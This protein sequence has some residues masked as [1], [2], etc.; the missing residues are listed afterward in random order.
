MFASHALSVDMSDVVNDDSQICALCYVEMQS[1]I[2][3]SCTDFVCL[4]ESQETCEAGSETRA[5][6]VACLGTSLYIDSQS[7]DWYRMCDVYICFDQY[8]WS[9]EESIWWYI[10]NLTS[11]VVYLYIC[12]LILTALEESPRCC[13]ERGSISIRGRRRSEKKIESRRSWRFRGVDLG[14]HIDASECLNTL[15]CRN[16]DYLQGL[17]GI[18]TRKSRLP[19]Y[20]FFGTG[21]CK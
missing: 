21:V 14:S 18:T 16:L 11:C 13:E 12:F 7:L 2:M 19:H 8:I 17:V 9:W 3:M 6:V 5:W 4:C 10:I 1:T 15:G 20:P